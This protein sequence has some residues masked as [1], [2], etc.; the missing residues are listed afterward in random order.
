MQIGML[1]SMLQRAQ[2]ALAQMGVEDP[3]VEVAGVGDPYDT[4]QNDIDDVTL[5]V[6]GAND[7]D[8]LVRIV[9]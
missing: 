7:G 6:S 1:I 8:T 2:S 4:W 9:I 3:E 5:Y